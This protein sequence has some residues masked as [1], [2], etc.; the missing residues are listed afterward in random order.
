MAQ[1]APHPS[2]SLAQRKAETALLLELDRHLGFA[3]HG[4]RVDLGNGCHVNVDGINR[5]HRFLCEIFS[6]IGKLQAAQVEKVASDIL[7][8]TLLERTRRSLKRWA[9]Q[10]EDAPCS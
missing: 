4:E 5:E 1:V 8:L 2:D 10:I 6:R 9:S 3:V 7:K